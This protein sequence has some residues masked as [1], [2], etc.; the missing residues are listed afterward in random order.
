[1]SF[2]LTQDMR[3]VNIE[4]L[5]L[6]QT[7]QVRLQPSEWSTEGW[8]RSPLASSKRYCMHSNGTQAR[9]NE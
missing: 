5:A 8:R 2:G 9:F 1:M 3:L 4:M 7:F 6:D